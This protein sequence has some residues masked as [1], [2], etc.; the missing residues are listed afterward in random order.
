MRFAGQSVYISVFDRAS[1]EQSGTLRLIRAPFGTRSQP[2][3]GGGYAAPEVGMW[4]DY[5]KLMGFETPFIRQF[6]D[7]EL[8]D[9][10]KSQQRYRRLDRMRLFTM[11]FEGKIGKTMP[12]EG[13]RAFTETTPQGEVVW[14]AGELV[15][16]GNFA[17]LRTANAKAY[18][19]IITQLMA[20]VL[21]PYL[22][23]QRSLDERVYYTYNDLPQLYR[24]MGFKETGDV[25]DYE[26]TRWKVLRAT[27]REIFEQ[28]KT[29]RRA[30]DE[31]DATR[32]AAI[33][34]AYEQ[35]VDDA[36]SNFSVDGVAAPR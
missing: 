32:L 25:F 15:E 18:V 24:P 14:G 2:V 23:L 8:Y 9:K 20:F 6:P 4:G 17:I 29:F 1:G 3:L 11:P 10:E 30:L 13:G 16:P 21:N 26:G 28:A 34:A 22:P 27:G 31:N 7:Y 35:I 36:R 12:R 33:K 5:V 19:E